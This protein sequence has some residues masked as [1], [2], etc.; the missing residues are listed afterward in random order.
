MSALMWDALRL[1]GALLLVALVELLLLM[2]LQ[3]LRERRRPQD[4]EQRSVEGL[5]YH[6]P[7]YEGGTGYYTDRSGKVYTADEHGHAVKP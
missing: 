1:L 6:P 4:D 5:V 7:R 2:G 3:W